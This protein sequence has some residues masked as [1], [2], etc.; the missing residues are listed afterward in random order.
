MSKPF[1]IGLTGY[2]GSGKDTVRNIL[3]AKHGFDGIAFADPIRDMLTA[4]L[5]SA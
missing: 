1:I 3:E 2:A 5:E 4:L